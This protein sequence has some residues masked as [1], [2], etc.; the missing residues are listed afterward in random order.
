MRAQGR[1]SHSRQAL[2]SSN[3]LDPLTISAT[4]PATNNGIVTVPHSTSENRAA[5]AGTTLKMR[6]NAS[7]VSN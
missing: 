1:F 6:S 5:S 4:K 7:F 3:N 2:L